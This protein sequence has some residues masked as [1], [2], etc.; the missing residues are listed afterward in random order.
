[1][2]GVPSPG[3]PSRAVSAV[4]QLDDFYRRGSAQASA[5]LD[6]DEAGDHAAAAPLYRAALVL[7]ARGLQVTEFAPEE[8]ARAATSQAR[9]RSSMQAVEQRLND[10][11][12][13]AT[14]TSAVEPPSLLER[15]ARLLVKTPSAGNDASIEG[16]FAVD[17]KKEQKPEPRQEQQRQQL[18]SA[19]VPQQLV[20]PSSKP[21]KE[22]DDMLLA[23][24]DKATQ[25]RILDVAV[26]G[27]PGIAWSDIAGLDEAKRTLYEAVIL[28]SL[29]PD[30]FSGLRKPASGVLLFGPPGCGKTMLA[31]A[32]ATEAKCAFFSISCSQ[33]HVK[34]LGRIGD[35]GQGSLFGGTLCGAGRHFS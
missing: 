31:K 18:R 22:D 21:T 11:P 13:V 8:R 30:F 33:S 26:D 29:R 23:G 5:G 1:M 27:S 15:L 10:M 28:P 12:T 34:I 35:S 3:P 32:V 9:I 4:G 6:R 2:I 14:P 25:R 16:W 17:S 7:F 19:S 24:V 20:G